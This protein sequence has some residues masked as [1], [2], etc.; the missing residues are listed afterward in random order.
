MS[1]VSPWGFGINR[2][3]IQQIAR[4]M[5]IAASGLPPEDVFITDTAARVP[6]PSRSWIAIQLGAPIAVQETG[7]CERIWPNEEDWT[8]T[9]NSV[10][11]SPQRL[12][13]LGNDYD[14]FPAGSTVLE[15]R[16]GLLGVIGSPTG[17]TAVGVD[18]DKIQI[19]STVAGT[20]LQV[21]QG[22]GNDYTIVKNQGNAFIRN[23]R[24]FELQCNI[25]C[26]GF[27]S[28]TAPDTTQGGQ[29]IADVVEMYFSSRELNEPMRD[30]GH[31]PV[32]ISRVFNFGPE[33]KQQL[34]E[35]I[36]QVIIATTGRI[37]VDAQSV[38][39]IPIIANAEQ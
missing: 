25:I 12:T 1:V 4:A 29:S 3:E 31:V 9:I 8:V 20:R 5:A 22:T 16:D 35:S 32:R 26:N 10:T 14:H 33:N 15:T 13:V 23:L 21:Q 17:F 38:T 34:N 36:V 18:D 7:D 39:D 27:M 11:G 37:D 24:H 30:C 28:L 2:A 6:E 19:D